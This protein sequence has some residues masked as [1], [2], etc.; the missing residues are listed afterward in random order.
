MYSISSALSMRV[1]VIVMA[2]HDNNYE[3]LNLT[4]RKKVHEK[5]LVLNIR[6]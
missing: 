3:F 1:D 5:K 6:F 2:H 4:S